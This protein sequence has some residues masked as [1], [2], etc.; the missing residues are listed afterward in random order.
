MVKLIP[1][2]QDQSCQNQKAGRVSLGKR[3]Q[4]DQ[5]P[6]QARKRRVCEGQWAV[7]SLDKHCP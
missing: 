7:L 1:G 2:G 5:D 6:G 3:N 4:T